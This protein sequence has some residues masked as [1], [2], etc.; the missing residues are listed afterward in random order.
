MRERER[1]RER[2]G[3]NCN[4][5]NRLE[6]PTLLAWVCWRRYHVKLVHLSVVL[7]VPL[8]QCCSLYLTPME[9]WPWLVVRWQIWRW[10]DLFLGP[11]YI[12][13]LM[14]A[15]VSLVLTVPTSLSLQWRRMTQIMLDG[16]AVCQQNSSIF[17]LN[18]G[19]SRRWVSHATD[20]IAPR[21]SSLGL[22]HC[23][24]PVD[25]QW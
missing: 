2:E 5:W 19:H 16:R 1:E 22:N 18:G 23:V 13:T 3:T 4:S 8:P 10:P 14:Y 9:H 15:C 17:H 24:V 11:I 6:E 20:L 21:S 12:S 7:F 25:C